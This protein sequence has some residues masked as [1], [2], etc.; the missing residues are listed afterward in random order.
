MSQLLTMGMFSVSQCVDYNH[1]EI[2]KAM[3]DN[4]DTLWK[5]ILQPIINL[6][7]WQAYKDMKL[8]QTSKVTMTPCFYYN[9]TDTES[10]QVLY[11]HTLN[12]NENCLN[13]L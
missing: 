3:R 4:H 13:N 8:D 9:N 2:P 10:K 7:T 1:F 6:G 5:L 12:Q 11:A